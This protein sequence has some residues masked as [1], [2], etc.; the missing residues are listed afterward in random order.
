MSKKVQESIFPFTCK[1]GRVVW[2]YPEDV[3]KYCIEHEGEEI[4]AGF[5]PAVKLSA[6]MKLYAFYHVNILNCAVIGYT[7]AGYEGIDKVKA[8]YL[9]RAEFCKDFIKKPDG[10][11]QPIMLDKR[12]MTAARLVK[13][14]QD[15]IMFI[16]ETLQVDVPSSEEYKL[17]K[18]TGRSFKN[19][20]K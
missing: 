7:Y 6:K 15:C 11:Y 4:Y 20:D 17:S 13:F 16:E 19:V 3:R 1:D 2:T 14:V 8:D 18:G 12:N 5:D 9:L 10:T